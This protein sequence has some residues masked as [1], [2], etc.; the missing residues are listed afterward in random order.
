M[1]KKLAGVIIVGLVMNVLAGCSSTEDIQESAIS[2]ESEVV[3]SDATEEAEEETTAEEDASIIESS[4]SSSGKYTL[5]E[6]VGL[7]SYSGEAAGATIDV[8]LT[9]WGTVYED[10]V[11][12]L[13]YIHYEIKNTGSTGITVGNGMF[14]VYADNYNVEQYTSMD[15]VVYSAEISGGRQVGGT[16]YVELNPDTVSNIEVECGNVVW[17][18]KEPTA[19][20]DDSAIPADMWRDAEAI[21]YGDVAGKYDSIG[22]VYAAMSM[23]SSIEDEY[24]GNI[25]IQGNGEAVGQLV[26]VAT[27]VYQVITTDGSV[28]LLGIYMD[29]ENPGFDLYI[30]GQHV[31]YFIMTSPFI[32]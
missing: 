10:F 13:T 28:V 11:G 7:E 8:T 15:D 14:D 12:V 9:E 25:E 23:Y 17:V 20:I 18:I 24:I 5:G 32:S 19:V 21:S 31:D 1:K 4:N 29:N 2:E 27:N 30:D 26:E 16:I 3:E 6:T 22:G